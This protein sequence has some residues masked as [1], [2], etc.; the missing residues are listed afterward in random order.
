M[1][2]LSFFFYKAIKKN[3]LYMCSTPKA[4][5]QIGLA[6]KYQSMSILAK[7]S[8]EQRQN[9]VKKANKAAER[10]YQLQQAQLTII[11]VKSNISTHKTSSSA[12]KNH[13]YYW[14]AQ[15]SM[16]DLCLRFKRLF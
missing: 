6:K 3:R 12:K 7:L 9:F 1:C 10:R 13:W 2:I 4:Q 15:A 16:S 14:L 8:A 11:P 5:T